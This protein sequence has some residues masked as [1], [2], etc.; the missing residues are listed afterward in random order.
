MRMSLNCVLITMQLSAEQLIP[1]SCLRAGNRAPIVEIAGQSEQVHRLKELG[2][3]RGVQLEMVR[4]GT[5]CIVRLQGHT[6]CIRG[7]DLLNVF[8]GAGEEM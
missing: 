8:V 6:L 4:E 3:R 1:L 7:N 2:F 5:P